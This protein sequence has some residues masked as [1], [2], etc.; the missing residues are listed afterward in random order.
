MAQFNE[1]FDATNIEP[2]EALDVLPAAKYSVAITESEWKRTK[3]D[4][5]TML[6]LT[7]TVIDGQYKGR[8]V[9]DRLN[10]DNPNPAAVE[11]AQKT[12][13]AICH[14]TGV[15][16]VSDSTQ[17]H[18]IPLLADVKVKDGPNGP[19]NEVKGYAKLDGTV[20]APTKAPA[21]VTGAAPA[22]AVTP[23]WVKGK[24]A[25]A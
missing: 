18:D 24:A 10:L 22:K 20:A 5:G 4:N 11:I 1:T 17:L 12:L 3:N 8:K 14:A 16:K 23:P 2:R 7:L 15:M 21:A 9:W 25:A 13:A 19:N 6:T